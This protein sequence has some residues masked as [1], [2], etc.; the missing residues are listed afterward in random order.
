MFVKLRDA[1]PC[2][3][4][5]MTRHKAIFSSLGIFVCFL[6]VTVVM[7]LSGFL[8]LRVWWWVMPIGFVIYLTVILSVSL[9][10]RNWSSESPS[11]N[12]N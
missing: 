6:L 8:S 4:G 7:V 9:R 12:S 1:G 5:G 11:R 2:S 3:I 10:T